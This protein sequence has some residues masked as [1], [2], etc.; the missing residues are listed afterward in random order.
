MN[1]DATRDFNSFSDDELPTRSTTDT[2]TFLE[3][4]VLNADHKALEE[5]LESN[6]V[7]QSDLDKCLVRG[8][9]AVQRKERELTQMAQTLISLL[10]SGAKWNSDTFLNYQYTPYHI[11]CQSPGDHHELLYLMIKSFQQRI[12]DAQD[13]SMVTVFITAVHSFNFNCLKCLIANVAYAKRDFINVYVWPYVV[14]LGDIELLKLL[15]NYGFDKDSTD[16]SGRSVLWWVITSRN[17]EAVRYLLDTG[18][19]IPNNRLI[20]ENT[21]NRHPFKDDRYTL[22]VDSVEEYQD[23]Y[24]KA[25]CCENLEIIKLLDERGSQ[26]CKSF[27]AL[28]RAV[29]WGSVEVVSYLL[30]KYTYDLNTEYVYDYDESRGPYTLFTE[31]RHVFTAEITK[32][33]LDHGA[34]PAKPMCEATSVNA[35]MTAIRYG[36]LKASAQYIRSGVNIN[37][38]S[39][40]GIKKKALPFE[41]SALCGHHSIAKMLLVSGCSC[42]VFSL[43]NNNN[44]QLI[45]KPELEKLMK[46]WKVQ[47]NNVTPLQQRCRC[48]IL[49]HLS[50]R[51]DMKIKTLPLP[52]VFIKF[53][54]IPE[55]DAILDL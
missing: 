21:L 34:D 44:S 26:S 4:C 8:L 12:T 24:I 33:L 39:Y 27:F 18:V 52:G 41:T 7:Q 37:F 43:K 15:F 19:E 40:D 28:R 32:L 46:E 53:L 5:H 30:N 45:I 11:I 54:S 6:P 38:R 55:L 47:E 20:M 48:V 3:N 23:P 31:H 35:I 25:I 42:G 49:N 2:Y 50:P 17:V 14:K 13:I 29:I 1:G 51:A 16:L 10:H 9:Q 22:V 36:N